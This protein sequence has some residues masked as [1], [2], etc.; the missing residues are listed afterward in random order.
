MSISF[1]PH[2]LRD[3]KAW[4]VDDKPHMWEGIAKDIGD[5]LSW[6]KVE[7]CLNNPQFFR[8]NLPHN[9][10]PHYYRNWGDKEVPDPKDI[11]EAVN[12]G[13]TFIIENYS[14]C[15]ETSRQLMDAFEAVFPSCQ[16]EMHVYGGTSTHQSFP[17]HQDLAN[18]FIIQCEG[19]T[20][21]TVYNDR[22]SNLLSHRETMDAKLSEKLLTVAIDCTL[23]KGDVLYIPA[24][25]YHRAQP[26]S[27]RLSLSVPMMH[28]C[29]SKP[30]DRKYYELRKT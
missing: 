29:Q 16:G 2:Q 25:C 26:D 6:D 28:L 1:L 7:Y 20:H 3:T 19:E 21:W 8:I 22:A 15:D 10:I 24:R 27:R 30:Y 11:F 13:R 14:W 12:N 18:N 23:K 4:D 9:N 17:I 5:V